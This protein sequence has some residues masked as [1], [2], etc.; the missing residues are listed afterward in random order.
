M[1]VRR[2]IIRSVLATL[3]VAVLLGLAGC[4][5]AGTPA[6]FK[7]IDITGASYA[8]GFALPDAQGQIRRLSDFQGRLVV[9]FFGFTQCPD[10]CPTTMQ[11]LAEVKRTLGAD[12]DKVVG[13]FV[14]VDP[15]RDTPE[16][17]GPY[18]QAFSPDFV[19]LRGS[20]DETQALA[21]EFKVFFRKV[22]GKLAADGK[23]TGYT[24]DHTAGSFVFDTKGRIRLFT[25]YG[26][27]GEALLHDLRLLLAE[28]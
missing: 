19:A 16:V 1:A 20:L 9:V 10:V 8:S 22:P 5:R 23:S 17:L 21:K 6:G 14:T 18:V 15:E 28:G 2:L 12:G 11:E 26:T 3:S 4:E 7:A 24:M 27:G 25:R 13:V